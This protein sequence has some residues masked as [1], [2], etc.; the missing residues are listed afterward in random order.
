MPPEDPSANP[1]PEVARGADTTPM[2]GGAEVTLTLAQIPA[3]RWEIKE[4]KR[5]LE[6]ECV[7]LEEVLHAS[8]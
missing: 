7:D 2:T 3:R 1:R 5:D 8:V 6:R 4:A